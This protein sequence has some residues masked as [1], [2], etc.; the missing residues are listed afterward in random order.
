VHSQQNIGSTSSVTSID[1]AKIRISRPTT[2]QQFTSHLEAALYWHQFGFSVIPALPNEKRTAVTWDSWLTNLSKEKIVAHWTAHPDHEVAFI[3]GDSIIVLDADSPESIA[4]LHAIE[5]KFGLTSKLV[6]KTS[7]GL[8]HFFQLASGTFVR[9][10]SHSTEKHPERIDIKTGRSL[11][12]LPKSTGKSI[13]RCDIVSCDQL[14]C[15]SQD[16]IDAVFTHNGRDVPRPFDQSKKIISVSKPTTEKLARIQAL[17]GALDADCGR[18]D[19]LHRLMAV[20]H[21]TSGSDEGFEIADAWSSTGGARYKGTKDVQTQWKSFKLDHENPYTM[22]T[23]FYMVNATGK[24]A[25]DICLALEPDFEVCEYE[26]IEPASS[27]VDASQPHPL[28]RFSLRGQSDE[29][30]QHVVAATPVLDQIALKGQLTMIF[31]SANTGKT[32]ITI[33]LL[34]ESI[35]QGIIDPSLLYY[36]NMD[37]N[38][39]GLVEK[40]QLADEF[41]FH[42][43]ADGYNGFYVKLFIPEI[44]LMIDNN[45]VYGT[46]LILDTLKKFSNV[47]DKSKSAAFNSLIRRFVMKGGTVIAL[48]HTNKQAGADGKPIYGG[49]SDTVDDAD[50]AFVVR[51]ISQSADSD[52]KIVEFENIKSRGNVAPTVAFGY[53]LRKDISYAERLMSVRRVDDMQLVPIKKAEQLK[54]DAEMIS[55]IEWCI[56]NDINSKMLLAEKAAERCGASKRA[57]IKIIEKYTGNDPA[58]HRWSF[59]VRARGAKVFALLDQTTPDASSGSTA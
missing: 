2:P 33:L 42:M 5:E 4:A 9:P 7:K 35:R 24:C 21:E 38:S 11:V 31:A 14:S 57:V 26:R 22:A 43:L 27:K 50:C 13:E 10:D 47:M 39:A 16:V 49:T 45:Q 46:V 55:A 34:I 52:E 17:L 28:E 8:H 58:L 41:G 20:F 3:V 48:A 19:W 23:L 44:E 54:S 59:D 25:I 15:V 12:M 51:T 40:L 36:L 29:L 32:L 1:P 18:D 30:A 56:R 37:D 6:N 53:S